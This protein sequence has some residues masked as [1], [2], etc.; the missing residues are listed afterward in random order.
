MKEIETGFNPEAYKGKII[1]YVH[2]ASVA[3]TAMGKKS[4]EPDAIRSAQI[5]MQR[6]EQLRKAGVKV[7]DIVDKLEFI[8]PEQEG[9]ILVGGAFEGQCIEDYL[10]SARKK[11]YA[12]SVDPALSL[13]VY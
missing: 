4:Q 6:V 1:D 5:L 11:G 9:M 2:P 3:R 13:R 12:L 7:R 10:E 8:P